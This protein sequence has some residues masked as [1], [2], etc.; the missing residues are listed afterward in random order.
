MESFRDKIKNRFEFELGLNFFKE[1]RTTDLFKDINGSIFVFKPDIHTIDF[2]L[3][4]KDNGFNGV[5]DAR[6]TFKNLDE[7][8]VN[9]PSLIVIFK[10]RKMVKAILYSQLYLMIAPYCPKYE[11]FNE[12]PKYI[13]NYQHFF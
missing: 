10:K 1:I 3:Y 9:N 7:I 5:D 13:Y 4:L 6:S 12:I 2:F 8:F 11:E